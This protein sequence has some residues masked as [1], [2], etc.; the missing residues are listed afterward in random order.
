M[1]FA[2]S[3]VYKSPMEDN[4]YDVEDYHQIAEVFGTMEDME[5]L[6]KEGKKRNI[7][8]IMDLVANHTSKEHKWFKEACKSVDNPYHDFFYWR[9]KKDDK[10]SSF[11]GSSWE[12]VPEL[13][14]ILLSLFC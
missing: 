1:Q 8:I 11:G 3:P 12:Y 5:N 13:N 4:G 7:R 9:D 6:I 2:L 10:E 14:K